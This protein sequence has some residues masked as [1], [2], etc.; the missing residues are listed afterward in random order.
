[1]IQWTMP[2]IVKDAFIVVLSKEERE[3]QRIGYSPMGSYV[4]GVD[5]EE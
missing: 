4:G 1:M 5:R 3:Y 2:R